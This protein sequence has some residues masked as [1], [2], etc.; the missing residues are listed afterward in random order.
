MMITTVLVN[1][2]NSIVALNKLK[3]VLFVFKPEIM[4]GNTFQKVAIVLYK[5]H[6]HAYGSA[7]DI[8]TSS[9]GFH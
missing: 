4:R 9:Y 2:K 6:V 1:R 3:I 8:V 7:L 5:T